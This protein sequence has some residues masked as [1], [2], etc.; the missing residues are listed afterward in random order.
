MLHNA[1]DA[2]EG[3]EIVFPF[4]PTR[5]D[6]EWLAFNTRFVEALRQPPGR[7]RFPGLAT[8]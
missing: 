3:L 4:D 2:A 6:F 5:D 7:V 1:G 8:P